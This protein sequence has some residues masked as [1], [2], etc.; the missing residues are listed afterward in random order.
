MRDNQGSSLPQLVRLK[1]KFATSSLLAT[2]VDY[3]LY[4]YLV[5]SVFSPVVSN[6]ISAG[7]GMLINFLVQKTFVFE[8]R[9][10]LR[11]TFAIS[12]LTSLIGLA[13]GTGLIYLFN[14]VPLLYE[15]QFI[16]KALVIGMVFFYNFYMKRFAFEKRFV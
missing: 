7:T 6:V 4:L 15:N 1:L 5:G 3:L 9:R 12:L 2:A 10:K 11:A 14:K 16:T 13:I 8:L